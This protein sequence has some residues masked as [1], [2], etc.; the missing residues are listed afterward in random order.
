MHA[1]M[2]TDADFT[3]GPI[4]IPRARQIRNNLHRFLSI[5]AGMRVVTCESSLEKDV[6]F[7]KEGDPSVSWLCEQGIRINRPIGKK[8]YHTFDFVVRDRRGVQTLIEVKPAAALVVA[9]DGSS[10]PAHWDQLT[11]VCDDLGFDCRFLTDLD[12]EPHRTLIENWESLLPF[13]TGA[14][15]SPNQHLIDHLLATA[16][17]VGGITIERLLANAR[18]R[19]RQVVME[20]IAMLLHQGLLRA[21]LA[22]KPWRLTTRVTSAD[23]CE[24]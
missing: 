3:L 24:P 8:P 9:P 16:T 14:Y 6:A 7:W 23:A 20:H 17:G 21:D 19:D 18:T 2:R 13:A 4:P 15:E 5:K 10:A 11:R 22:L 1:A 12:V